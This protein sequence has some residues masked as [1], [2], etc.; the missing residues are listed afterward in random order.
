MKKQMRLFT[1]TGY[2]VWRMTGTKK[3]IVIELKN[4]E[5]DRI[6]Q[7]SMD[8]PEME[9]FVEIPVPELNQKAKS[10]PKKKKE[11][12]KLAAKI[13]NK[14]SPSPGVYYI[15]QSKKNPWR[16]MINKSGVKWAMSFKTPGEAKAALDVKLK[17]AGLQSEVGLQKKGGNVSLC[18]VRGH[19]QK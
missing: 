17:E 16:A 10:K 6:K 3:I 5:D 15:S 7:V 14:K 2:D 11:R 9:G 4:I 18:Y 13:V 12:P 19:I 1:T 8:D